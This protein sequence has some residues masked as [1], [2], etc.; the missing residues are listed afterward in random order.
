MRRKI[1]FATCLSFVCFICFALS[2]FIG[3]TRMT[4][5]DFSATTDDAFIVKADYG[6][7]S[8][9][10]L[11]FGGTAGNMEISAVSDESLGL[12]GYKATGTAYYYGWI[13]EFVYNY[14][15]DTSKNISVILQPNYESSG[16][17]SAHSAGSK[18]RKVHIE[19]K[20]ASGGSAAWNLYAPWAGGKPD[21]IRL[22]GSG[23]ASATDTATNTEYV[24]AFYKDYNSDYYLKVEIVPCGASSKLILSAVNKSTLETHDTTYE[25]TFTMPEFTGNVSF[26]VSYY[27]TYSGT[28]LDGVPDRDKTTNLDFGIYNFDNDFTVI[29]DD[30]FDVKAFYSGSAGTLGE[31]GKAGIV[32]AM[33]I[34]ND[35]IGLYG[36]KA[37]G[38][39]YYYGWETKFTY[40]YAIDTS[41]SVSFLLEPN[42]ESSGNAFGQ[43]N[44]ST[45]C[46]RVHIEM[47]GASGGSVA[48]NLYAPWAGGSPDRIRFS[49]T[50]VASQADTA[51]NTNYVNAFYAANN[52]AYYL[53]IE[54]IPNGTSSTLVFSAVNKETLE[55][56]DTSF[57][58][59]FSMPTFTGEVS[60]AVSYYTNYQ[61][62]ALSDVPDR[63][64]ITNIAFGIYNFKNKHEVNTLTADKD[65]IDLGYESQ[66]AFRITSDVSGVDLALSV[67]DDET[68][69]VIGNQW[70]NGV[71]EIKVKGLKIGESVITVTSVD[72]PDLQIEL[73]VAVRL[74]AIE[75]TS[76]A[77]SLSKGETFTLEH[78]PVFAELTYASSD[79]SVATVSSD[80]KVT[81]VSAGTAVITGTYTDGNDNALTATMTVTV[82]S[83]I[84]RTAD[85]AEVG[86][87]KTVNAPISADS[88]D[89]V[90]FI[91]SNEK[92][93]TVSDKGVIT[94]VKAGNGTLYVKSGTETLTVKITVTE[95]SSGCGSAMANTPFIAAFM[96]TVFCVA[97]IIRKRKDSE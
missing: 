24:K 73:T 75:F 47:A 55:T 3:V 92:I 17:G 45:L 37:Y 77:K 74:K 70:V 6:A 36:Y 13:T 78:T 49:G 95:S 53:K 54:I 87:G 72:N 39:A 35:E 8:A 38:T 19:L 86:V 69:Q 44:A 11:G 76:S 67:S 9:G 81:A 26:T 12:Y 20:G 60:L 7:S 42:Y 83:V 43:Y 28:A 88:L 48:W 65:F 96:T 15:V 2:L 94:G 25:L 40:D 71:Y 97:L 21:R 80:G 50:G 52:S 51:T 27:D 29:S 66:G 57:A 4:I 10:T 91:S 63:E 23:S 16:D 30:D 61:T 1:R 46:R 22:N 82:F 93:F 18:C 34:V 41:K 58:H 85:S 90:K 64:K 89:G 32:A 14:A 79:T 33:P 31:G 56:D 68:I 59:T 84:T 62:T 5:A